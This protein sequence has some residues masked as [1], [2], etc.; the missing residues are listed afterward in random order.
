MALILTGNSSSLTVDSTSGIT[1][2][3]ATIQAVA[4]QTGPSFRASGSGQSMTGGTGIKLQCS[5]EDWDTNNNYDNAT[6]YRFT[7]TVA[8]YYLVQSYVRFSDYTSTQATIAYIYKNGTTYNY[9]YRVVPSGFTNSAQI[10][11]LIYMNGTT[12]YLEAYGLAGQTK[13]LS[14]GVFSASLARVA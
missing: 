4:A 14:L 1:F 9:D 6:N 10:T 3:N 11:D 2:P 13:T 12:D 8:G 7:P 5:T